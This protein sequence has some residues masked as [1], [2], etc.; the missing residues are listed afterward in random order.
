VFAPG[1]SEGVQTN[2]SASAVDPGADD[3][4]FTWDFGDGSPTVTGTAVSHVYDDSDT[5]TVTVTVDDGDGGTDVETRDVLI[6]N[7]PP[8]AGALEIVSGIPIEEGELVFEVSAT[9]VPGA[10]ITY[11]W[12]M[13]DGTTDTTSVGTFT[14]TYPDNGLFQVEVI[15]RDDEGLGASR[16]LSL[17]VANL[18]PVVSAFSV[19][20]GDPGEPIAY[21]V[22]ASD[23]AADTLSYEWDFGDGTPT[24]DQSSGTHTF[25]TDGVYTVTV[26]VTDEDGGVTRRSDTIPIGDVDIVLE[27]LPIPD[28]IDEGGSV[29][30]TAE[31]TSF[32]SLPLTYTWDPGDGSATTQGAT[33][34]H[35]Y[36]DDGLY[37]AELSVTD[38][39]N[40]V[41]ATVDIEVLNVA[42]ILG[43]V[44]LPDTADEGDLV[45]YSFPATDPGDDDLVWTWTVDGQVRPEVV[46]TIDV[47]TVDDGPTTVEV[48]VSDGDGGQQSDVVVLNVANVAPTGVI[49]G[50]ADDSQGQPLEFQVVVTEPGDDT[51]RIDWDFGDGIRRFDDA[52]TISHTYTA[53]G[54]FTVTVTLRDEDGGIS[55]STFSVTIDGIGPVISLFVVPPA[56]D[57]GQLVDLR[58]SGF[59]LGG[60]GGVE[61]AWDL[62]DGTESDLEQLTYAWA[63]DGLYE[64]SCT[65]T[66]L[67][68]RQ[69]V[70]TQQVDVANVAPEFGFSPNTLASEGALYTYDPAVEDPGDDTVTFEFDLPVG[71]EGNPVDGSVSWLPGP[72]TA[73]GYQL[74]ITARD[75][76]GGETV[77]PWSLT[78]VFEDDDSD[79]LPDPW[80]E[81]YSF[82]SSGTDNSAGDPDGDGRNNL[83]EYLD[84]TNPR[85]DDRP[86]APVA[87]SPTGFEEVAVVRPTLTFETS[88]SPVG[89][90]LTYEVEVFETT[91]TSVPPYSQTAGLSASGDEGTWLVADAL[92]ENQSFYWRVRAYDGFGHSEWSLLPGFLVNA[93]EEPPA[94]PVLVEPAD[95]TLIDDL[96]PTLVAR[97]NPDPDGDPVTL[98]IVIEDDQST[99]V[100]RSAA[101]VPVAGDASYTVPG[102]VLAEGEVY[103][104]YAFATDDT[105][106]DSADSVA[107][108]FEIEAENLAPSAPTITA[109]LDGA[110]VDSLDPNIVVTNGVDPEGDA[111]SVIIEIDVV[112]TYDS[113]NLETD[114][115]PA[116]P[117]GTTTR[118]YPTS[119][120]P[121]AEDQTYYIRARMEETATGKTSGWDE[122]SIFASENDDPPGQPSNVSPA[123]P[124]TGATLD[125]ADFTLE[126]TE[127]TDPEG[128]AVRY[129]FDV[130]EKGSS[131]Q[132][133]VETS[134]PLDDTDTDLDTISWT[135]T[136]LP[137]GEYEW[138]LQAIDAGGVPSPPSEA[139]TLIVEA[140]TDAETGYALTGGTDE[141]DTGETDTDDTKPGETGETGEPTET[142]ET[143]DT[144][145]DDGKNCDG[146]ANSG[147]SAPALWLV[148]LALVGRRRRRLQA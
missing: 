131:P 37:T 41:V 103:T 148:G 43:A 105:A 7:A 18:P 138:Y 106:L 16:R 110:L 124:T 76:D 70:Q 137:A 14:H 46:D 133:I 20:E 94:A 60:S 144:D 82:D 118:V 80:E 107:F 40:V 84:G 65:V 83:Q 147:P 130:I 132:V 126:G 15:I 143:G 48:V 90:P 96:T 86:S 50:D 64:V 115:V 108:T 24:S 104:W 68:G 28:P 122:I 45:T 56:A 11:E 6:R 31:A 67:D 79:G 78:V 3:L 113:P 38:G 32:Q 116:D 1:G 35:T 9:D 52:D 92:D 89:S 8:V 34:D 22:T 91:N 135:V 117:S 71:A 49:S 142:G 125:L 26:E 102:G 62:D 51:V 136:D 100:A 88:T 81:R 66:D 30:I 141:T 19:G 44:V 77:V 85:V 39:T 112:N 120:I 134:G 95:A 140:D 146:C 114:M 23:V 109:P 87:L 121:L 25:A 36:A 47:Q 29:E 101:L 119:S 98:T 99:E 58:C 93:V 54:E 53:N 75:E 10:P 61:V 5:Y 55:S 4:T 21:S 57:E 73:G 128:T 12:D 72:G 63:D 127:V 97:A 123:D 69:T 33:L 74:E 59:D 139:W 13:G 145:P 2:F 111:L 17:P 27:P 42:P 129:V